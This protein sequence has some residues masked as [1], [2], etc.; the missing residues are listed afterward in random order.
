MGEHAFWIT[1]RAAGIVGAAGGEPRRRA[2][3]DDEHAAAHGPATCASCTSRS[4]WRRSVALAVHA[5]SLLGRLLP[6]AEPGRRHDPVRRGYERLWMS[7]GIVAGWMFVILGLSYYVRGAHRPAALAQPAPLHGTGLG[8]RR[9]PRADDGHG[10]GRRL[11]PARGRARRDPRRCAARAPPHPGCRH[12]PHEIRLLRLALRRLGRHAARPRRTPAAAWRTGTSA[13]AASCPPAS[14]RRLNADPREVVPVSTTMAR[15]VA[16]VREAAE[17]TGGLVDGTLLGEIEA[18]GYVGDLPA[19]LPLELTLRLAPRAPPGRAR[20]RTR[21]GASSTVDGWEVTPPAGVRFDSGG[22][23]K[24]LFADLIAERL[25]GTQLRRRLRRRSALRRP[26]AA[27]G[28][29]GPVRRARRCTSSSSRTP[30]S[31]PAGSAGAAGSAPDGRPA[32]HLLDPATGRAR[33]HRRR[34]GHGAR[35]DRRRGR[36]A[37]EGRGPVAA[38][39]RAADWLEHGG[40]VVLDDRTHFVIEPTNLRGET[41]HEQ[42]RL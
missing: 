15:L 32:H 23:A 20:T 22:L 19:P 17:A 14:S 24:G 33:V 13:S 21:A 18:A 40:V 27:A 41:R 31:R 39:T 6:Q 25:A 29:R 30:R 38:P 34:P 9:R 12:D 36:M 11:V 3:P 4:R 16:A 8:A 42:A 37:R 1:S 35:A 28:G 2:R 26:A 10:R 5:L 7:V